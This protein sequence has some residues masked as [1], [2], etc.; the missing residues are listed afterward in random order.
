MLAWV[1]HV[2]DRLN[3]WYVVGCRFTQEIA[4]GELNQLVAEAG[5]QPAGGLP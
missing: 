5:Q 2:G 4:D 3:G 1:V